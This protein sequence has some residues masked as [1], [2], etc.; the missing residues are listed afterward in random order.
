M[1]D[2]SR[3]STANL[4]APISLL[5]VY[6]L[7][8]AAPQVRTMVVCDHGVIA[9]THEIHATTLYFSVTARSAARTVRG[10]RRSPL[11]KLSLA[12]WYTR[13]AESH[14]GATPARLTAKTRRS[15]FCN[16]A[17]ATTAV[18]TNPVPP[19]TTSAGG[20]VRGERGTRLAA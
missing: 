4:L 8:F 19:K 11:T 9:P 2:L 7:M 18:P 6:A 20:S 12:V 13:S 10:A 17:C 14:P 1:F 15:L 3:V 16:K 5:M